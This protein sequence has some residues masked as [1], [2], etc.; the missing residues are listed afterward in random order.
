M[1]KTCFFALLLLCCNAAL[2]AQSDPRIAPTSTPLARV[3]QYTLP[4]LDNEALLEEEMARRKPGTAP[5]FAES[6]EVDISPQTHGSWERL[7]DGRQAWRLRVHSKG[8]KSLNLGFTEYVMPAGGTLIL[9]TPGL[10]KVMGPFTPADNEE[11]GQLWT[12]ILEGDELVIEVVLPAT[13]REELG[14]QLRYVNHDFLGAMGVLSGSCNVDVICSAADG[15]PQVDAYRDEIQSVAVISQGGTTFCTGFLVSNTRNDCTPYFMTAHHCSITPS[16]APSIV[17]HWN[18]Q[19]SWC[20]PPGS[21]ASGNPGDGDLTLFNTGAIYR[22]GW[23]PSDFTL[24]ELDDP[25]PLEANAYMA[26]WSRAQGYEVGSYACIHHPDGAEKRIT[27]ADTDPYSGTWG[28]GSAEVENGNHVVIPQW[29]I[30]ST[31]SGSSGSPLFNRDN[32]AIGQLHGGAANCSNNSYDSYGAFWAS[33]DGGNTPTTRLKDWLDPDNLDPMT[34]DGYYETCSDPCSGI[35]YEEPE[36]TLEVNGLLQWTTNQLITDNILIKTGGELR[37]LSA[38]IEMVPYA[39]IT[40]QRGARLFIDGGE[41]KLLDHECVEPGSY[42]QG[43]SVIGNSQLEQPNDPLGVLGPNEAGVAVLRNEAVLRD[44]RHAITTSNPDCHWCWSDYG[45]LVDAEDSYFINCYRATE[46]MKYDKTNKSRYINCTFT[47]ENIPNLGAV[48]IWD[49]DGIVFDN[50]TFEEMGYGVLVYDAGCTIKNACEF[51]KCG[52]GVC[53]RATA[54]VPS[55]SPVI[56]APEGGARN[57]FGP[58]NNID[59]EVNSGDLYKSVEIFENDFLGSNSYDAIWLDG[60]SSVNIKENVFDKEDFTVVVE[61]TDI[62]FVDLNCN[63]FHANSFIP[64]YFAGKNDR[65]FIR[66]NNFNENEFGNITLDGEYALSSIAPVQSWGNAPVKNCFSTVSNEH[67]WTFNNT[68]S[69]DYII[70]NSPTNCEV[71]STAIFGTNNFSIENAEDILSNCPFIDDEGLHDYEVYLEKRN[72]YL[73]LLSQYQNDPDN[74]ALGAL[75]LQA[76]RLK[77]AAISSIA[78]QG[79]EAADATVL[80]QVAATEGSAKSWRLLYGL[81]LQLNDW[82]AAAGV[83]NQ[84]GPS[85]DND[86]FRTVQQIN[87]ARLQHNSSAF[88]LDEVQLEQLIHIAGSSSPERGH[89]RALLSMLEGESYWPEHDLSLQEMNAQLPPLMETVEKI[90]SL[91]L[92]PNPADHSIQLELPEYQQSSFEVVISNMAGLQLRSYTFSEGQYLDMD[93]STLTSGL[94]FIQV[95]SE[96]EIIGVSKLA[97]Q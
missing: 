40:I 55:G 45:G 79:L 7:P 81:Y 8:A 11:H 39:K 6:I 32:R 1:K 58:D 61:H 82:N 75:V 62:G 84:I 33:W 17:A 37:I 14:L 4:P 47:D 77:E 24:V 59:I 22:A 86:D 42:W 19:N 85:G 52:K 12:P 34:H 96:E 20:R 88:E 83:L 90:A 66:S 51:T 60:R 70:P 64:T 27:T 76:E 53:V 30:G 10:E 36:S 38:T 50:C 23:Q 74:V 25:L 46:F 71:P 92:Y 57:T 80:Q 41:I 65:T 43:I 5:R 18:Y 15:Q 68:S 69:F 21:V 28:G 94:Y 49:T 26:G 2:Y 29:D 56:I 35:T 78:R 44:A 3:A 63:D 95:Q 31:E 73:N 72:Q 54:P 16:N 89:A 13:Q 93:V 67:I 48:S 97:I 9:Y 87:L 91:K